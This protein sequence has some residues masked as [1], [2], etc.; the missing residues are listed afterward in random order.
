M[1]TIFDKN[2]INT[3][4]QFEL[5]AARGLAVL[6]MVAVHV[7][8][9]YSSE[10][11]SMSL[12]GFII[13]FL[14][15]PPAA[16]VFMF[17]LG[18]GLVYSRKSNAASLFKRGIFIL[19]LGYILNLL[20]GGL[21][22]LVD[23][24]LSGEMELLD[25]LYAEMVSVDILQFAGLVFLFFSFIKKFKISNLGLLLM[26]IFFTL[27]NLSL[28]DIK[29]DQPILSAV[30]GLIW[31][32]GESSFFPFL[33]W[34]MYPTTGYLF[35]C[36]LA[37]CRDKET[38]YR[39]LLPVSGLLL[40][41]F[42]LVF[43]VIMKI[44]VGFNDGDQY[45]HQTIPANL[46]MISF[47]LCWISLIYFVSKPLNGFVKSTIARW[48]RNVLSLY[49]IHWVIIGWTSLFI[50]DGGYLLTIILMVG[51][52]VVSDLLA[53]TYFKLRKRM[54]LSPGVPA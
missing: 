1:K 40:A 45:F 38:F 23:S 37:K 31:G 34:I 27:L 7:L 13:D 53:S 43:M 22:V 3:G 49:L 24:V 16:P 51:L 11:V 25:T 47:A 2:N 6:F 17:I 35:A 32:S 15:S 10:E 46:I 8:S 39:V 26:G 12:F 19:A 41:A 30:S 44:D 29:I 48:N 20:R 28:V 42:S 52:M 50:V 36:L 18:A 14:G 4:R 21:P 9:S 5:D 54:E 33:S